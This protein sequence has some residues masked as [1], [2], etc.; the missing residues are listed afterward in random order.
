MRQAGFS[1]MRMMIDDPWIA[2]VAQAT[3]QDLFVRGALRPAPRTCPA[4]PQAR[5]EL[6]DGAAL[7]GVSSRHPLARSAGDLHDPL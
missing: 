3:G 2:A 7:V 6:P 4:H 1:A 5:A